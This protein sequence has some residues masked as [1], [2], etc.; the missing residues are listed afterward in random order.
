MKTMTK[1]VVL[2]IVLGFGLPSY[3][4]ILVYKLSESWTDYDQGE[5][6][7]EV[8]K[9]SGKAYLVVD[10]DYE[11]GTI[12]NAVR[13]WYGKDAEGKWFIQEPV[14]LELVRVDDSTRVQWVVME[15]NMEQAAEGLSGNFY[16]L[17]GPARDRNVGTGEAQEVANK[18]T[19][20]GLSDYVAPPRWLGTSK[21]S[22]TLYPSWTYW[23]NG[24]GE[25]EGNQ[26]FEAATQFIAD[27]L[28]N[29]GYEDLAGT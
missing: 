27:Y 18:L 9:G 8:D 22:A 11:A 13:I 20:Y 26:D 15:K 12:A 17:T 2:L 25:D 10:V 6:Q 24:D 16:M 4:E 1:M 29:K 19:G 3:G 23:A 21:L 5:Q 14:N 28:T 7:W